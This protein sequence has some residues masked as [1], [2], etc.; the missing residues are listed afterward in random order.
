MEMKKITWKSAK[1]HHWATVGT[2]ECASKRNLRCNLYGLFSAHWVTPGGSDGREAMRS[3]QHTLHTKRYLTPV[4]NHWYIR[5]SWVW[6][7]GHIVIRWYIK[8][9]HKTWTGPGHPEKLCSS[10]GL[11]VIQWVTNTPCSFK[12]SI[13]FHATGFFQRNLWF[14]KVAP[15]TKR[16]LRRIIDVNLQH[17]ID[18]HRC[19]SRQFLGGAKDILPDFPKFTRKKILRQTFSQQIVCGCW[20]ILFSYI[21]SGMLA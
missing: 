10:L 4:Q 11:P 20:C 9:Y 3:I 18:S 17:F 14:C 5:C 15:L 6:F 21:F 1:Q 13:F 16:N 19:R 8:F 2:K 12:K 7:C